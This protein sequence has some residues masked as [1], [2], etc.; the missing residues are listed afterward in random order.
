MLLINYIIVT[1]LTLVVLPRLFYKIYPILR[2][3]CTEKHISKELKK[4]TDEYKVLNDIMVEVDGKTCQIDHIVISKYGIFVI[5]TKGYYGLITGDQYKDNWTQIVKK[6][7]I[8]Y[9]SNPIR[10]N[11]FHIKTLEKLLN[12]EYQKFISIICFLKTAELRISTNDA[13]IVFDSDLINFI[14]SNKEIILEDNVENIYEKIIKLNI[15]DKK[16]RRQHNSKINEKKEQTNELIKNNICP[17]CGG[18]IID[19]KGRYGYFKG[20]SNYPKCKF[21]VRTQK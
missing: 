4:L 18:N 9:I 15:N 20:C 2:G 6:K 14:L 3:Q 7:K 16:K 8:N 13:N 10:Q 11:Y 17:K 12:I 1:I 19:K 5:E 21:I